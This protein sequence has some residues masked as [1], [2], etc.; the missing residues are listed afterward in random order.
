[1]GIVS[2]VFQGHERGFG[3]VVPDADDEDD[4]L[5]AVKA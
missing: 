4:L 3:F 2:G 5:S 1:M